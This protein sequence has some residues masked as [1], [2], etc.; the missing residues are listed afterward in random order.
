M[1]S[2]STAK[3]EFSEEEVNLNEDSLNIVDLETFKNNRYFKQ[4]NRLIEARYLLN[5]SQQRIVRLMARNI[6]K[7][8]KDFKLFRFTSS[9]V[10][11]S[12]NLKTNNIK[13]QVKSTLESL[14]DSKITIIKSDGKPL[15]ATWISSYEEFEINGITY[16]E[17][18]FDPKLKPYFLELS[19]EFTSCDDGILQEFTHVHTARI[20][21]LLKQYKG[22]KKTRRISVNELRETLCLGDKYKD[23]SDLRRY[24]IEVAKKEFERKKKGELPKC[25]LT[26]DVKYEKIRGTNRV[27]YIVF[28][29]KSQRYQKNLDIDLNI[30]PDIEKLQSIDFDLLEKLIS[31][32]TNKKIAEKWILKYDNK[33]I[34]EQIDYVSNKYEKGEIEYFGAYLASA[35]K[36]GWLAYKKK[37]SVK[38]ASK[39]KLEAEKEN[40]KRKFKILFMK[41]WKENIYSACE[42]KKILA[43]EKDKPKETRE[44]EEQTKIA[45]LNK[46]G[47]EASCAN[48]KNSVS[49]EFEYKKLLRPHLEEITREDIIKLS[50]KIKS[51]DALYMELKDYNIYMREYKEYTVEFAKK[52]IHP[53][54]L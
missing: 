5:I 48:N 42:Y 40:R 18:C 38:T 24:V 20:Y 2:D 4:S 45:L 16:Y 32:G 35:I 46:G 25:D 43:F 36:D 9:L 1:L 47:Y 51:P 29:I 8:D 49:F 11:K 12:N 41:K 15:R 7:E 26:F 21:A 3:A 22:F 34:E 13:C 19:E 6:K 37:I 27:E 30:I 14:L 28:Y 17:T 33:Y 50:S 53:D 54:D 39:E 44:I 52:F 31:V 23:F 10:K